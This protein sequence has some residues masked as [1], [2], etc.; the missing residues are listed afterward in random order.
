MVHL[1]QPQE[2]EVFYII[3]GLK[4][5]IALC[6]KRKGV[7]QNKIA[8]LLQVQTATISQYLHNKRGGKIEFNQ[9]TLSEIS[10]ATELITDK[11]SYLGQ[12]QKLM[13]LIRR[14]GTLCKVHKQVSDVPKN[15]GP[16][17]VD[18]EV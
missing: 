9:E 12:M 1:L 16:D 5:E 8:E 18:C 6:L 11:I 17:V 13:K 14:N 4:R 10:L 7:K 3:P 15:C 2:V